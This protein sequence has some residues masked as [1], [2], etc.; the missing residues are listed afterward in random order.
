[1]YVRAKQLCERGRR[2][3]DQA[4]A[5]D[6]GKVGELTLA[7]VSGICELN[8]NDPDSSVN[9]PLYPIL[10]DARLVT[11]HGEKMLFHGIQ[12][13][14]GLGGPGYFQE[15]SVKLEPRVSR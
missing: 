6:P 13:P 3:S 4:I 10:R 9:A 14:D 2:R 7:Q 8:L 11:M 1:M 15:W 5:A 12:R